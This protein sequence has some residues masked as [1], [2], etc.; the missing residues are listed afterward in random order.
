[1]P[2]TSFFDPSSFLVLPNW[3]LVQSNCPN[4]GSIEPVM[5][6]KRT[7]YSKFTQ[8]NGTIQ[9]LMLWASVALHL[10][11]GSNLGLFGRLD[12]IKVKP[13][14]GTVRVVD[15]TPAEQ[16]RVPESA[17]SKPLPIAQT[18]V[19]PEIATRTP[20]NSTNVGRS[21]ASNFVP[22]RV[23]R[24]QLPQ[25]SSQIPQ[26]PTVRQPNPTPIPST[27]AISKAPNGSDIPI[28]RPARTSKPDSDRINNPAEGNSGEQGKQRK[29]QKSSG[30]EDSTPNS[31]KEIPVI[32]TTRRRNNDKNQDQ[33]PESP[34]PES[35]ET[36]I[37]DKPQERQRIQDAINGLKN[38][39]NNLIEVK[40]PRELQRNSSCKMY[41][42]IDMTWPID[43]NGNLDL[44]TYGGENQFTREEILP[45]GRI[46]SKEK[47]QVI[48]IAKSTHASLTLSQKKEL[49][50]KYK[51][52]SD[53]FAYYSFKIPVC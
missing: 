34:P 40:V 5:A 11:I 24:P 27:P 39:G 53:N 16:T 38:K 48:L 32:P 33:P 20:V 19:N 8:P 2:E 7:D 17:K 6:Q 30:A 35:Q 22:P 36:V 42:K 21:G 10:A 13:A 9:V 28:P 41:K 26:S 1:V 43:K 45:D 31:S 46:N 37:N 15:L 3:K 47:S 44:S 29:R 14:G 18:P 4:F 52:G 23:D 50:S 25:P 51:N 49:L 12:P